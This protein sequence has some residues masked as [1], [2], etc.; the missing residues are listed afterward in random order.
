VRN[1]TLLVVA[2]A[3]LGAVGASGAASTE[4][5]ALLRAPRANDTLPARFRPYGVGLLETRLVATAPRKGSARLYLV[6]TSAGDLCE[7]LVY[8]QHAAGSGC[9]P[10]E[11]FF[12]PGSAIT[13]VSG[14]FFAGVAANDVERV[15]LIDRE[16]LRHPVGLTTDHGFI[17]ACTGP[18]GC[19]CKVAWSD[20][21]TAAGERVSHNRWLA[22]RCWRLP[23]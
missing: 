3:L 6:Q 18:G 21:Y 13:A 20:A 5:L 14:R 12:A 16:G 11:G 8:M 23:K 19:A 7:L 17:Y 15:V 4:P 22:P 1:A 9:R 2:V 10:L